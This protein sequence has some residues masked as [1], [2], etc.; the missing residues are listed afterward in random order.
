MARVIIEFMQEHYRFLTFWVTQNVVNVTPDQLLYVPLNGRNHIYWTFGHMTAHMDMG[1]VLVPGAA[2]TLSPAY[3]QL[4]GK[5]TLPVPNG[6]GYP[7]FEDM[8]SEFR[9]LGKLAVKC[10]GQLQDADLTQPPAR[11]MPAEL[12]S[13]FPNQGAIIRGNSFHM[14]Y[15][16]GQLSQFKAMFERRHQER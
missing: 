4:F 11:P 14:A 6:A 3:Q 7:P 12:Q 2:D 5:G 16:N 8:Q 13:M 15:H 9:R 1:P 10:I